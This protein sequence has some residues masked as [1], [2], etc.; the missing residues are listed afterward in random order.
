M[1]NTIEIVSL[2]VSIITLMVTIYFSFLAYKAS[3]IAQEA[4]KE[5]KKN[6]EIFDIENENE[7]KR[8][9]LIIKT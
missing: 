5:L 1:Q 4:S 2:V 9:K 6:N 8:K 3:N 7:I